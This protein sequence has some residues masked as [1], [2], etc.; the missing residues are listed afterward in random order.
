MLVFNA[1]TVNQSDSAFI[2]HSGPRRI[3]EGEVGDGDIDKILNT[4]IDT[5]MFC[6]F[7][8][9]VLCRGRVLVIII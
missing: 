2:V 5:I 6:M 3:V 8:F 9:V 4:M 1:F 7:S